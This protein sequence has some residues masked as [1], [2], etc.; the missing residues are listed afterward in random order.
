[1][2]RVPIAGGPI[3]YVDTPDCAVFNMVAAG[4]HLLAHCNYGTLRLLGNAGD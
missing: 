1:L 4:N 2:A 3:E